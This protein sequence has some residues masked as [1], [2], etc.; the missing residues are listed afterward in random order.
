MKSQ[1]GK[2]YAT[3]SIWETVYGE[4]IPF[5]EITHQH[6]SNVYWY[7]LYVHQ[8][9]DSNLLLRN[10]SLYDIASRTIL[11]AKTQLN[12]RFDGIILD[13][14]PMHVNEQIWFKRQNTRKVLL[15]KFK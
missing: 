13:W 8:A 12:E 14:I 9:G 15:E 1:Y 2:Y 6:W 10:S 4:K 5:S 7:Y 11:I 3:E